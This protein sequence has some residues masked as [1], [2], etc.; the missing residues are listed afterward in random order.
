MARYARCFKLGSKLGNFTPVGN[1]TAKYIYQEGS[2]QNSGRTVR[3]T[4]L[5]CSARE[6]RK[7]F[8]VTFSGGLQLMDSPVL[9]NQK[10]VTLSEKK[11]CLPSCIYIFNTQNPLLTMYLIQFKFKYIK[12][13]EILDLHASGY[14]FIDLF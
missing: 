7:N 2:P 3:G 14:E 12:T 9:A 4:R 10:G 1:F 13:M 11:F 8:S 5:Q 6:A